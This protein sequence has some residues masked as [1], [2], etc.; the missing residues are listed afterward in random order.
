V[1]P[2]AG[3]SSRAAVGWQLK[4]LNLEGMEREVVVVRAVPDR[5]TRASPS[6]AAEIGFPL[7]RSL[8][9]ANAIRFSRS[10][11]Q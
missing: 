4:L 3:S 8:R 10:E 7:G 9:Q 2:L 11:W 1:L 6:G 5:W